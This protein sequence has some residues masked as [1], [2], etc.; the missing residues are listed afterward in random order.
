MNDESK[1]GS[2]K[3][4]RD[5]GSTTR[6]CEGVTHERLRVSRDHEMGALSRD[7][8]DDV[9][10]FEPDDLASLTRVEFSGDGSILTHPPGPTTI[11][12]AR[13]WSLAQLPG[14]PGAPAHGAGL[15]AAA[16]E[17]TPLR[18]GDVLLVNAPGRPAMA[19]AIVE[20]WTE[21]LG[22]PQATDG[23][24]AVL[25]PGDGVIPQT[26]RRWARWGTQSLEQVRCGDH[27]RDLA[28]VS[29]GRAEDPHLRVV[30]PDVVRGEDFFDQ[31]YGDVERHRRTRDL[32]TVVLGV[33]DVGGWSM[34]LSEGREADPSRDQA[35]SE[36]RWLERFIALSIRSGWISLIASVKPGPGGPPRDALVRAG[37][38][39]ELHLHQAEGDLSAT[40]DEPVR[41]VYVDHRDGARDHTIAEMRWTA[42]HGRIWVPEGV[43]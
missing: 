43:T 3:F 32:E 36:A 26:A 29:P 38:R 23:L 18:A 25:L 14:W 40:R 11:V 12:G 24:G 10:W 33:T 37:L 7:A 15:G 1:P 42:S 13:S 19:R 21:A 28:S 34:H 17:L 27:P 16:A 31:L 22:H 41:C 39:G 6:S 30:P 2:D 9:A 5:D 8:D 35:G 20:Q 4:D